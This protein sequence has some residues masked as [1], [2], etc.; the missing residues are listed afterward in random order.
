MHAAA[1]PRSAAGDCHDSG[2]KTRSSLFYNRLFETAHKNDFLHEATTLLNEYLDQ[3]EVLDC[4]LPDDPQNLHAWMRQGAH[5]TTESFA[6]YLNQRKKGAAR[7]YFSN[8]AHAFH[9]LKSVAPTKLVDGAWLYG[10]LQHW[11][12]PK[13]SGLVRT[14]V[15]ELGTGIADRNHVVIYKSLLA[16]YGLDLADDMDDGFYTQGVIQLALANNAAAFLPEVIGFNLGYEQLP[17]HLL[18][19]A[20]ELNELNID[21]YYF[22]LHTTIDNA[23]TGHAC[24]AVHAVLDNLP[25]WGC[26]DEFWRRVQNGYKLSNAGMGTTQ[27]MDSFDIDEEIIHIFRKKSIAGSGVHSD[28]CRL[29]GRTINEWLACKEGIP[30]FLKTLQKTNWVV[31]GEPAAKSRFWNLLQG[32]RAEMSG[33]FSPYELQVIYDWIRGE[34]SRDGQPYTEADTENQ[35]LTQP[36]FRAASRL[37]AV[38]SAS[39]LQTPLHTTGQQLLDSDLQMLIEQLLHLDSDGQQATLLKAMAPAY[40]WT[41]AGLYATKLFNAQIM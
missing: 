32:S 19:T 28:Y 11:Q 30:E 35:R 38:R 8:R 20:Y 21:P 14:Y 1:Y 12:N 13:F 6:E 9:F 7:N 33:V 10:L 4:D 15:E 37:E 18:I 39:I 2:K 41:P 23:D 26:A 40:Q 17:L 36:S 34:S 22:T 5:L 24:R 29:A 16:R 27:V 25:Q 31:R 3:L